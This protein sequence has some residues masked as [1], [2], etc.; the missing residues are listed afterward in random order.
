MCQ[1]VDYDDCAKLVTA[2]PSL[3]IHTHVTS[4]QLST[5]VTSSLTRGGGSGRPKP[6]QKRPLVFNLPKLLSP[7]KRYRNIAPFV[8]GSAAAFEKRV[9]IILPVWKGVCVCESSPNQGMHLYAHFAPVSIAAAAAKPDC[10]WRNRCY[11]GG[12]WLLPPG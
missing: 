1:P 5:R 7:R 9:W 10:F 3:H 6:V 11:R 4:V 8:S 2:A 12:C